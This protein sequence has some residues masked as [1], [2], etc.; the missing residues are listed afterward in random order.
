MHT[1]TLENEFLRITVA[2]KGAELSSVWDKEN[3]VERLWYADPAIWNRHAP[4]LFPFVG[5][6]FGGCYRTDGQEFPMKTQHGF[7]RDREFLCLEESAQAVTHRLCADDGTL[8]LYPYDFS[9]TVRH[10]LDPVHPRL[11]HVGW[12]VNNRG[13]SLMRYAIGGHPGFMPPEGLTKEQCLLSFPGQELLRY[14]SVNSAGYALP[15]IVKTLNLRNGLTA[16]QADIPDTWIFSDAQVQHVCIARPDGSPYVTLHCE[17][18]PFLAVWANAK[19]P[20]ICLEPWFGRTDD[21][22]FTGSLA[23]KPGMELLAPGESKDYHYSIEF[24]F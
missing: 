4:I 6:V 23:E 24:H 20:Y 3:N 7:A 13:K 18:F 11:L 15:E 9:L 16:Y 17:D 1:H 22:G 14:F 8:S 10:S 19:G 5:R 2:D 21:E 12:T